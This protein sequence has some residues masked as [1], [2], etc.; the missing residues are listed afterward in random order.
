VERFKHLHVYQLERH[1]EGRPLFRL[2]VGI[3][4]TELEADAILA[5]LR[6]DYPCASKET[7]E[8]DDKDAVVAGT[9]A[10]A[11][12]KTETKKPE[13]KRPAAQ[14][15]PRKVPAA[16]PA[17]TANPGKA[18][19]WDIDDVLPE[20]NA[21]RKSKPRRQSS[22]RAA[23]QSRRAVT[24]AARAVTPAAR[25]VTPAARAATPA[26]ATP[27]HPVQ[28][29]PPRP[30]VMPR[31]PA[32]LTSSRPVMSPKSNPP[33]TA[34]KITAF[35]P[36]TA[37][38][39]LTDAN[40]KERPPKTKPATTQLAPSPIAKPEE[41]SAAKPAPTRLANEELDCD[42]NAVTDQVEAPVFT[43]EAPKFGLDAPQ[44]STVRAPTA[45]V[46]TIADAMIDRKD[47]PA[48][49]IGSVIE[50][51]A[52]EPP[53]I[54][55]A[56]VEEPT[57]EPPTIEAAAVEE[58]TIEATAVEAP[59]VA[60]PTAEPPAVEATTVEEPT[61]EAT[62]VEAPAV[63]EPTA[64]PPAVEATAVEEPAVELQLVHASA[65]QPASGEVAAT[66]AATI[67][68][69]PITTEPPNL[70]A[71]AVELQLVPESA[72]K[73]DCQVEQPPPAP[74]G[75]GTPLELLTDD[76]VRAIERARPTTKPTFGTPE[77]GGSRSLRAAS[78]A[79]AKTASEAPRHPAAAAPAPLVSVQAAHP[80]RAR[81]RLEPKPATRESVKIDVP[82][83]D[84]TQTIRALAPLELEDGQASSGF[85]IQLMVSEQ[86][87]DPRE[88][89]NLSIFAEYRLYAVTG[90][91]QDRIKHALRLGFFSSQAAAAAVA[92]YMATFFDA[93]CIKRVSVAEHE[94]FEERRVVAR[95]D[96]GAADG[97]DVIELA[98]PT[99]LPGRRA[100][101]R[102]G[103]AASPAVQ[104]DSKL[105]AGGKRKSPDTSS[106]WSRLIPM[107]K[108]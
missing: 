27:R 18:F 85:A 65:V 54:E 29:V 1:Q 103:P 6:E 101:D 98:G 90:L 46:S 38:P 12:T 71:A 2:R 60:E 68:S 75:P 52:V 64:E 11:V 51:I 22:S 49:T 91:D 4:E 61:I 107:R 17:V 76:A 13:A 44:P 8:D 10:A 47:I 34:L 89:P 78:A 30:P 37:P 14:P 94:R 40:R 48:P 26:V 33:T 83:I 25:A 41:I 108:R 7:A 20:L 21:A 23:A 53:T 99:P 69:A 104:S 74:A 100:T 58:P 73:G 45:D 9:R 95:K 72:T 43:F 82:Q 50:I 88:V 93:P 102:I 66:D 5:T 62:A 80:A 79:Q 56:A 28:S 16:A 19:R 31:A 39:P 84:R 92:G 24:P 96:I 36:R 106:I 55:A 15:T 42:P 32:S 81:E 77:R 3:I 86:E 97:H 35:E 63:A 59:A 105:T 57:V 70:E 87:I 67:T